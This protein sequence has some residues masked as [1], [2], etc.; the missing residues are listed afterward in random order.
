ML[1]VRLL[2]NVGPRVK[3]IPEDD[4]VTAITRPIRS[5]AEEGSEAG[6]GGSNSSSVGNHQHQQDSNQ[7]VDI[8][9]VQDNNESGASTSNHHEAAAVEAETSVKTIAAAP[10]EVT[11]AC[12]FFLK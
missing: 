4:L 2:Q 12:I 9:V 7:D 8:D 11:I 3:A 5:G 10:G 6:K 1:S